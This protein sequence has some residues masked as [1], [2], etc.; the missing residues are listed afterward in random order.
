MYENLLTRFKFGGIDKKG[1]YID[2]TVMR[3]CFTHRRIMS[4][5]ALELISEGKDKQAEEVLAYA[6]KM[7]PSYNVPHNYSSGSIDLARAWA[8]IGKNKEA[9]DIM[10]QMWTTASQYLRWYC[11]L[12]GYRFES[13]Q[14]DCAIQLYIMQQ[15][16]ALGDTF[17]QKWS[18]SHMQQLN[19]LA[20]LYEQRGGSLGY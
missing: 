9:L 13:A 5:L 8:T 4:R 11:T 7:V 15:L 16:L 14:N 3:M 2:E 6:T 19:Q 18:D 12:D 1:L 20:T 17:D 10:N